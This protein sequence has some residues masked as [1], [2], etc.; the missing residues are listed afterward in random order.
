MEKL[1]VGIIGLGKVSETHLHAYR[2]VEG[3]EVVAGAE[4]RAGRLAQMAADWGFQGYTDFE[5]MLQEEKLDIA[6]VLTPA[7]THRAITEKVAEYGVHVLCEKPISLSLTDAKA[8]IDKCEQEEVKLYYG[9]SY[10]HLC[11]CRKAK[12]MID[13][14]VLGDLLLLTETAIGG[15]GLENWEG[16]SEHHYPAGGPGGGG[17]GLID[18]GIHL[19]D[20]FRWFAGCEVESV[21]GRGNISGQT[22]AAEYLTMRFQ[23][24]AV[25]Q[26]IYCDATFSS[27]MPYEG[28]FSWGLSYEPS[29][30]LS[31]RPR[32]E[33]QPGSI[34]VHGTKG[35]LR[36]YHYA[37][38]L[39][40]SGE[41]R[42]EQVRVLDRPHPGNF[43]LQ[44]ES[45][46]RSILQ[47]EGPEVSGVDGFRA[48]QVILAAYESQESQ[49]VIRIKPLL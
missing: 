27:D 23:N 5:A 13:S 31:R 6:C 7:S 41:N 48:L 46:A 28:I 45:F 21:H 39:F 32:W 49:Q 47:G 40:F 25:G 37:N 30:A 9:S 24:G 19:A 29:G 16:L 33:A 4:P 36:I 42:Q 34:R 14:G 44:M 18:H 35:A 2:E 10:R 15:S 3:I 38:K 22:P 8:M 11:A 12:E 20:L 43:G 17:M 1:R 26:L